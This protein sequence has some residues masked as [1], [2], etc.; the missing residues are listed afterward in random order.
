VSSDWPLL[1]PRWETARP[2][3]RE[4]QPT[5]APRGRVGDGQRLLV[6][7]EPDARERVRRRVLL[8]ELNIDLAA[9]GEDIAHDNSMS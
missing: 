2:W 8:D 1:A 6:V 9:V 3:E 5:C 7:V 4:A